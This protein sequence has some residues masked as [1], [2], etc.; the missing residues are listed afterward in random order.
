MSSESGLTEM[1]GCLVAPGCSVQHRGVFARGRPRGTHVMVP[2][3]RGGL[4]V[5][6]A[7]AVSAAAGVAGHS[8]AT[9][10]RARWGVR[11]L[12]VL[13]RA[14]AGRIMPQLILGDPGDTLQG[15]LE[16]LLGHP[17]AVAV[18]L[19]PPRANRKPVLH[20]LD[21]QGRTRAFVKVGVNELTDARVRAER[22]SLD[23]VAARKPPGLL[24]PVVRAAGVWEGHAYA[25]LGSVPTGQGPSTVPTD[26]ARRL[27]MAFP[28]WTQSPVESGWWLAAVGSLST[29]TDQTYTSRL[30]SA[31][32]RL[33]A[34][35][36][37]RGVASGA[38]HGD[39]TPW[40]FF[41][42]P[43][44]VSVWDWE[45]FATDRPLGWDSLH[46][47]L[48]L[49]L[50][51]KSERISALRGVRRSV[52]DL[53]EAN[54]GDRATSTWVYASYLWYRGVSMVRDGQLAAGAPGGSLDAWLLP[55]LESILAEDGA[56]R[57]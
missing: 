52:P 23:L 46:Y 37:S 3:T 14:R 25:V 18:H 40:N 29:A 6:V 41:D 31:G 17:V 56:G 45:R 36:P 2:G 55:E 38:T 1:L 20:V 19:G 10:R 28:I 12:T 35:V 15:R 16:E 44:G 42:G 26:A 13:M 11:V 43:H 30:R 4:L 7:P 27:A 22:D 51:N 49:A 21:L 34:T 24:V 33:T 39:F 47:G 32:D 8:A 54:G 50:R 5:P 48:S 53:V 57:R 9:G